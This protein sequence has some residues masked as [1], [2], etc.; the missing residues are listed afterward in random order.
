MLIL[1]NVLTKSQQTIFFKKFVF[2]YVAKQNNEKRKKYK[3]NFILINLANNTNYS[4]FKF[5]R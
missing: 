1:I 3:N 4:V 2:I 5:C